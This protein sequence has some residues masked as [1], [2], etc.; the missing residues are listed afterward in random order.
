V[1]QVCASCWCNAKNPFPT[2]RYFATQ[3][4]IYVNQSGVYDVYKCHAVLCI[5]VAMVSIDVTHCSG[6]FVL[7][8]M[9]VSNGNLYIVL[10]RCFSY[11]I[12]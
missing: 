8:I 6:Y 9:P 3:D 1:N 7:E 10:A 2:Q 12:V 5:I 4:L 11:F